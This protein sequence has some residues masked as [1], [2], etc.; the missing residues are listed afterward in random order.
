MGQ[1]GPKYCVQRMIGLKWKRRLWGIDSSDGTNGWVAHSSPAGGPLKPGFGLSGDVQIVSILSSRL[2]TRI[3]VRDSCLG[4]SCPTQAKIGLEWATHP[5]IT[6]RY[7][8]RRSFHLASR[9]GTTG[10]VGRN[11]RG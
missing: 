1:A 7:C 10:C 9:V 5:D 3:Y 4:D 2:E 11:F 6:E 8:R